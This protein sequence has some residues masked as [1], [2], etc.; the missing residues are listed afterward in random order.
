VFVKKDWY[1]CHSTD[2]KKFKNF[3]TTIIFF[4]VML[5]HK[6]RDIANEIEKHLSKPMTRKY[7]LL[8]C[9]IQLWQPLEVYLTTTGRIY[10]ITQERT[11]TRRVDSTGRC[12]FMCE[13]CRKRTAYQDPEHLRDRDCQNC[14]FHFTYAGCTPEKF[15]VPLKFR[16]YLI[17]QPRK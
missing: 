10:E 13:R 14:G 9:P 3:A 8:N 1:F 16:N 5:T 12:V 17:I 6:S 15:W 2:R 7:H 4:S 11:V